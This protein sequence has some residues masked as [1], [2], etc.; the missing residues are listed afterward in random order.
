MR[1]RSARYDQPAP[2]Y[3]LG[4]DVKRLWLID[5][6]Y[7]FST[8]SSVGQGYNFDYLKLK[9]RLEEMVGTFWRTYYLNALQPEIDRNDGMQRFHSWLQSAPPSG[10]KIIT[11][12]YNLRDSDAS[13][14]YCRECGT[15]VQLECPATDYAAD[16][17][18]LT[19]RSQKGVDVGIASLALTHI[20]SYD[21]LML[22]SGDGDLLDA[23]KFVSDA[24]KDIEL[25]VFRSG[26][27]TELQSWSDRIY[28][29]DDFAHEVAR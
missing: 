14:A 23:V 8:Q 5:G 2:D 3:D 29:I 13:H 4:P 18:P 28:W 15:T 9:T 6:A 11:K 10:P 7:L 27:A 17:H 12:L 1:N 19:R 25:V 16:T 26:V 21:T 24:G 20:D 22:S